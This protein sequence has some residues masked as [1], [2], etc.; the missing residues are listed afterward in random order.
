[1]WF[2]G[3]LAQIKLL[4]IRAAIQELGEHIIGDVASAQIQHL[5]VAAIIRE[6]NKRR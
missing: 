1:M 3:I 6:I 4:E 2:R 5:D